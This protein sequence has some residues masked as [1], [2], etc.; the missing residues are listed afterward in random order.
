MFTATTVFLAAV[1]H[2]HLSG[3]EL[4]RRFQS[5][6]QHCVDMLSSTN[7]RNTLVSQL[8]SL[9][10]FL[11]HALCHNDQ[12]SEPFPNTRTRRN[13]TDKSEADDNTPTGTTTSENASY[14]TAKSNNYSHDNDIA[15]LPAAATSDIWDN[16]DFGQ[17]LDQQFLDPSWLQEL[18]M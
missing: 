6:R 13:S 17:I 10:D 12:S 1:R 5:F 14:L 7:L 3:N 9:L 15:A 11:Q 16:F 4:Q 18:Q 2:R 8:Q